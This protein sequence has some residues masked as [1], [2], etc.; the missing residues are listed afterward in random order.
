MMHPFCSMPPQQLVNR[1]SASEMT[2]RTGFI[3]PLD[4]TRAPPSHMIRS[5]IMDRLKDHAGQELVSFL[6]QGVQFKADPEM[7]LVFLSH[8]MSLVNGCL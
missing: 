2:L 7:Q 1:S 5:F 8:L 4:V 3:E 6:I